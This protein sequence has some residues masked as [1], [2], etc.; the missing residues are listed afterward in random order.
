MSVRWTRTAQIKNNHVIEAIAWSKEIS[1]WCEKK[2]KI[3]VDTWIDTVGAHNTI[4]WTVD[5]ADIASF[6]KVTTAVM[7]DAEYWSF[8]Q[9]A[10][11]AELFIDGVGHDTLS[12]KM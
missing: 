8:V 11:K 3:T 2:H 10:T 9:K 5:Y 6:D 12:K 7:M 1:G 4:R